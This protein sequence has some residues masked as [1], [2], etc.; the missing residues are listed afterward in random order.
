MV[1]GDGGKNRCPECDGE[2]KYILFQG[3]EFIN[4]PCGWPA[5]QTESSD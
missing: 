4:V 1:A 5:I 3:E 2:I